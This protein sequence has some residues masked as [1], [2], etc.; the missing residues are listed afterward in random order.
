M[1]E[2]IVTCRELQYPVDG[3]VRTLL[4]GDRFECLDKDVGILT[5]IGKIG[6]APPRVGR[7]RGRVAQTAPIAATAPDAETAY[8]TRRMTA[9]E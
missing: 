3:K 8:K 9:K 5:A 4:Q 7:P 1:A 6:L 2:M